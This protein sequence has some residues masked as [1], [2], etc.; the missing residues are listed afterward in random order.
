MPNNIFTFTPHEFSFAVILFNLS[1]SLIITLAIAFVYKK[2]H[3]GLSYSQS[4]LVTLIL[5]GII[6]TVVIMVVQNN[7]FG[8]LGLLGAFAL[9]RFRTILKETRDIS[10]VFFS[11]AEGVAVGTGN[12]PIA[13]FSTIFISL[14]AYLIN[15]LK[16]LSVSGAG[17]I[18][19]V[20]AD[21][22]LEKTEFYN[23]LKD[24]GIGFRLMNSKKSRLGELEY[25]FNVSAKNEKDITK[26][27]G[28]L[29]GMEFIKTYDVISGRDTGEY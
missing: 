10:F 2:T 24:A 5:I 20:S 22:A 9:I 6:S 8:A 14:V 12:Y 1:L 13:L 18:L 11:L 19:I 23:R 28:L 27:T 15:K 26:L 17:H 21:A 25:T 16:F 29:S 7:I 3:S 4:F